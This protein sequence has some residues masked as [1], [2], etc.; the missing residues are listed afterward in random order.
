MFELKQQKDVYKRQVMDAIDKEK[1]DRMTDFELV[2]EL[3]ALSGVKIPEA[4]EE[5]RTAPSRHDIVCNKSEMPVS[6]T[7]LRDGKREITDSYD[8]T[9]TSI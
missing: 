3:N 5:I 2:D 8:F 6:Y 7:H 4:I 1:Y 9:G